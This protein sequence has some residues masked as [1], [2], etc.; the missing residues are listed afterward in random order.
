[1]GEGIMYRRRTVGVVFTNVF[2]FAVKG[3]S[4]QKTALSEATR[5]MLRSVTII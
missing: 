1:L 4:R 3:E 2:R 5:M